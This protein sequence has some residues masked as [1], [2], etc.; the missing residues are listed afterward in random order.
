MQAAWSQETYLKAWNFASKIHATQTYAGALE[1]EQIPYTNHLGSV[2]MEVIWA[3]ASS[4]EYRADLAVQCALLHD[5]IEDTDCSYAAIKQQFGPDVADGVM[6]LT[7]D[8]DLAT[9]NEQMLDSLK[10]IK[11]QPK[12]VWMVK[13]ADRI[14][15]LSPPPFHWTKEKT[16]QYREEAKLIHQQLADANPFLAKRLQDKIEQYKVYIKFK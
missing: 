6:A 8:V 1:G 7:K 14:T 11:Q 12:E 2:A 15:N 10:R 3:L 16:H 13:L 4:N 5:S 9:K